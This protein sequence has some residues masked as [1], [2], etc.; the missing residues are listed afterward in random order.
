MLIKVDIAV[1]LQLLQFDTIFSDDVRDCRDR[2]TDTRVVLQD[3]DCRMRTKTLAKVNRDLCNN[4][5]AARRCRS[6]V[7]C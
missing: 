6:A 5:V 3:A 4:V 7:F 2:K 1:T